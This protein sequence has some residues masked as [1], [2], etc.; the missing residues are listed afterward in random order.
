MPKKLKSESQA[1]QSERFRE[2][3]RALQAAGELNPTEADDVLDNLVRRHIT[4]ADG[5]KGDA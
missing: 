4:L 1:D 3:V 5:L 2:A